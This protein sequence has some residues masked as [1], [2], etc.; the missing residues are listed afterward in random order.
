MPQDCANTWRPRSC[1][2]LRAVCCAWAVAAASASAS[3][4]TPCFMSDFSMGPSGGLQAVLPDNRCG[5]RSGDESDQRLRRVRLLRAGVDS[6]REHGHALELARQRA[7]V[8]DAGEM[9]QLADLLEADLGLAA[10][11]TLLD[12]E[13]SGENRRDLVR[14]RLL[15][16]RHQLEI[17]LLGGLG[18]Q[19][20]DFCGFSYA[21]E[22]QCARRGDDSC[23]LHDP[24]RYCATTPS[25]L[26]LMRL[27]SNVPSGFLVAA[28]TVKRAPALR[29][30]LPPT[31]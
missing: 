21:R 31:S 17:G 14:C 12:V 18:G 29:S 5:G 6:G 9:H 2:S 20:L 24:L 8:V 7:D 28:S 22:Q 23:G 30:P 15:E 1:V 27:A 11:E 4:E 19:H 26:T 13:R 25:R 16:L 3:V 10:R